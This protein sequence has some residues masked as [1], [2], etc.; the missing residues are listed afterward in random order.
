MC[1]VSSTRHVQSQ[2]FLDGGDWMVAA[3]GGRVHLERRGTRNCQDVG[4]R[5]GKLK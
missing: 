2:I 3:C 5:G 1:S 4:R